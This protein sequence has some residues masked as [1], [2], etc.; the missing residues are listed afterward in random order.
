[1]ENNISLIISLN[2]NPG[3][4]SH[5]VANYKQCE[6][7]GYTSIFYVNKEFKRFLPE[8]SRIITSDEALPPAK[9]A[10]I[11]F[12]SLKN[13]KLIWQLKR[14]NSKVL[15]VFHEPLAPLN[16]YR[17]AGFS[18]LYI[19]KVLLTHCVNAVT[20]N[21]S[22]T[23]LL[24]SHKAVKLYGENILY[25][26]KN[27]HYLPLMFPDEQTEKL[28]QTERQYFSYI[29]TVAK[30]HSFDEY[31]AFINW[32]VN[33]NKLPSLHFLI[34]TR[35]DFCIPESLA[36]SDR[37]TIQQGKPMTDNEINH[38]YASSHIVWNAYSRT[39]QSGVIAKSFM[40]GTPVIALRKNL[41]EF[42]S[43]GVE[44]FAIEDNKSYGQIE[45][46]VNEILNNF[47]S[48]SKACRNR[49][50]NSFHYR[51]YNQEFKDILSF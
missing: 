30:D 14:Q 28:Q 5:L 18:Y 37:V 38:W 1:M 48:Y 31:L 10:I 15:Y 9:F 11:T 47:D 44:V 42:S 34:A 45:N 8:N 6:E 43:H 16:T 27:Y 46:A 51:K 35:S 7:L 50:L 22:N 32:A 13:L 17:E 12:P 24:P 33:N 40:F 23:V 26:N 20:V 29:G 4:I 41:N 49:F 39:T 36:S 19:I 25:R 3:H 2:F 21:M